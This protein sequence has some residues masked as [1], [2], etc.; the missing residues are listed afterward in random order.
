MLSMPR[1]GAT[2]TASAWLD[3]E[4]R[5]WHSGGEKLVFTVDASVPG[6]RAALGGLAEVVGLGP[7]LDWARLLDE[8]G[9][10]G[11]ERLMVEGGS[12]VHTQLLA[13][14]LA[15]ELQVAVAPLL[16]GQPGAP[17]L[18]GTAEFPGGTAA[19]MRLLDARVA[20]D[21]VVLRY[22]PKERVR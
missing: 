15:D 5:F 8:L 19:R 9:A 14:D 4:L 3:P 21:S 18:V 11:V 13:M 16:V 6:L 12:S 22:A 2:V 17:R 7:E 1:Y 20:G 10:R